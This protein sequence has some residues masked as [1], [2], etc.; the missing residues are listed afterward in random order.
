MKSNTSQSLRIVSKNTNSPIQSKCD[1]I[2]I[3]PGLT[4]YKLHLQFPENTPVEAVKIEWLIPLLDI[5]NKWHPLIMSDR[6]MTADWCT[7]IPS[8]ATMGAPVYSLSSESGENRQTFALS[9]AINPIEIRVQVEEDSAEVKCEVIL[10]NAPTEAL[11]DY[12]LTLRIDNRAIP[13]HQ[14]LKDVAQ[15][16]EAMPEYTPAP[17][18]DAA[19]EPVYSTWYSFH[20]D[21]T[22]ASVEAQCEWSTELGCKTVI[23]DDGWQTDDS[24]KG[25]QFCGDWEIATSKFPDFKAHVNRVQKMDMRYMLWF[26]VPYAGRESAAWQTFKDRMLPKPFRNADCFDPRYPTVRRYLIDFY[27]KAIADWKIDGL[28][29][30]FVDQFTAELPTQSDQEQADMQSVPA[31]AD[32]LLSDMMTELQAINPDVLIEFRQSYI[33]PAMRK[34]GNILRAQDCPNDALSN[35]IRTIDVRLLAGDTAVHSDMIMWHREETPERAALQLW[36]ALFSVPQISV[37]DSS[38]SPEQGKMLHFFMQF[39]IE[40]RDLLVKGELIPVMPQYLYPIVYAANEQ[41]LL[42]AL[43]QSDLIVPATDIAGR[44]FTLV[45][46]TESERVVIDLGKKQQTFAITTYDCMG[47]LTNKYQ[48]EKASGIQLIEIS[49]SG[50]AKFAPIYA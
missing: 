39:W 37:K 10:F 34:Y 27:N 43:Y 50:L 35:R 3:T 24:N 6:S 1:S 13:Y 22:E 4:E 49:P 2:E 42:A 17:V 25:Y 19:F 41:D 5:S 21:L 40:N 30:D 48:L 36:A 44:A 11:E 38:I 45:N 32:R 7:Y 18:P 26:S 14:A 12:T 16:W 46:A 33:G 23:V 47:N 29:L 28:K 20:Q 31:A 9:D 8:Y 15:W